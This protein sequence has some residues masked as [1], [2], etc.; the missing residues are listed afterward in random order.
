MYLS[1]KA[2]A[3]LPPTPKLSSFVTNSTVI[4]S[5]DSHCHKEFPLV[6]PLFNLIPELA[7]SR[8]GMELLEPNIVAGQDRRKVVTW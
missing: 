4:L 6:S 3:N 7:Q 2:S 1:A 8:V 5:K